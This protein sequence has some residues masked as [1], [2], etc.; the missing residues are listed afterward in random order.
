MLLAKVD[1]REGPKRKCCLLFRFLF[2]EQCQLGLFASNIAV[3]VCC[4]CCVINSKEE[5]S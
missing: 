5:N 2:A 3:F 1:C 4:S